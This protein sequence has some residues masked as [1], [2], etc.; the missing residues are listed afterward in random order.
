M[1]ATNVVFNGEFVR[2]L[3]DMQDLYSLDGKLYAVAEEYG[4]PE[5]GSRYWATEYRD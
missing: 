2:K 1:D 5:Y 4:G 3:N